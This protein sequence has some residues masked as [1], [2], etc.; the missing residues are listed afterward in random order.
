M[1]ITIDFRAGRRSAP[2]L[3]ST[4]LLLA[5]MGACQDVTSAVTGGKPR[6]L[7]RIPL[8]PR[9]AEFNELSATDGA[10]LYAITKGVTAWDAQTGALLWRQMLGTFRPSN[11]VVRDGRVLTVEEFAFGLDAATGRELWRFR[12][13]A[14]G[15][16]GMSAADERAFYFGTIDPFEKTGTH[17][18]YALDQVTGAVL[19]STDIGPDWKYRG[20]VNGVSVSGDTV[21]AAAT[22]YNNLYGGL[23][24]GWIFALDRG[25]G[26]ILW[27]YRN[28]DGSDRRSVFR[29]PTV[30]GRLVLASDLFA[31]SFFAVD[32]FTGKE[33]WRV[34]GPIDRPG[35]SHAPVVVGNTAYVAS[36]DFFVYAV[37]L[38]TGHVRWKT[39][40]GGSNHNFAVCGNKIFVEHLG[41]SVLD[42]RTGRV[43]YKHNDEND[44]PTSGF[45]TLKDE[46]VFVFGSK[47][48]YAYSCG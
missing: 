24:T 6:I 34:T 36:N 22:Q 8:E 3:I 48:A 19:W 27:S 46:R 31:G 17:R 40:T 15:S 44:Y 16:L 12:P 23:A 21:Y 38:E 41:L 1:M 30:A 7:W 13:V 35:P 39:S 32:R 2:A 4:C 11:V 42:R 10:R 20:I 29:S 28:G 14:N 26:R 47:S 33:V 9:D 25:T 37:D 18:V 43:L 5:A 45:V